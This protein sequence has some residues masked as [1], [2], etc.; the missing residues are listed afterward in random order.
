[1]PPK[2]YLLPFKGFVAS[3]LHRLANVS[4]LLW[5]WLL[6]HCLQWICL[7]EDFQSTFSAKNG[8]WFVEFESAMQWRFCLY[9][10]SKLP[11]NLVKY[12]WPLF[13][14]L[15]SNRGPLT[16]ILDTAIMCIN[17]TRANHN[18]SDT[19]NHTNGGR[20]FGQS[21]WDKWGF[22]GKDKRSKATVRTY[23]KAGLWGIEGQ[24]IP[25]VWGILGSKKGDNMH[26][27]RR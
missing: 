10:K 16:H 25:L 26:I 18:N 8:V 21:T 1:M 2:L 5:V 24:C 12:F 20:S 7:Y 3:I 23:R 22:E 13:L 9:S 17:N 19:T 6:W 11:S 15:W 4:G 14:G 27:Q